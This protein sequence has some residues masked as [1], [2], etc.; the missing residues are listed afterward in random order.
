MAHPL[1][2]LASFRAFVGRA[3]LL[4]LNPVVA[5][6]ELALGEEEPSCH[7]ISNAP[8][9]AL[10]TLLY[11]ISSG[12]PSPLRSVI[13]GPGVQKAVPVPAAIG[14]LKL[15]GAVAPCHAGIVV[16]VKVPFELL[17]TGLYPITTP[18]GLA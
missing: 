10:Y 12:I 9:C 3:N 6:I 5:V 1:M 7:D 11:I 16:S 13:I 14:A 2:V 17:K 8:V 4:F 18:S 15:T